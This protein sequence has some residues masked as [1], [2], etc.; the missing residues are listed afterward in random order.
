M[1]DEDIE[2]VLIYRAKEGEADALLKTVPPTNDQFEDTSAQENT[3]YYYSI[4]VK[5]K[6]GMTSPR[7]DAVSAKL[8]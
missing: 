2:S 3:M 8:Q 5:Y 7:T 4:A 6:N 1:T